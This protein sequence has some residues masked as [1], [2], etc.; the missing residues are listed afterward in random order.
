MT[1]TIIIMSDVRRQDK[2]REFQKKEFQNSTWNS[3]WIL[4]RVI[5]GNTVTR[6][7]CGLLFNPMFHQSQNSCQ[8][9]EILQQQGRKILLHLVQMYLQKMK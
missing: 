6:L 7:R 5:V 2:F 3:P 1:H 8:S 4:A 9:S